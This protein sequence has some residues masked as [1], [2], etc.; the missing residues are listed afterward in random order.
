MT[1]RYNTL[2][3]ASSDGSGTVTTSG[4]GGGSGQTT[5]NQANNYYAYFEFPIK[6]DDLS[7]SLSSLSDKKKFGQYIDDMSLRD[8]ILEDYINTNVVNAVIGDSYIKTSQASGVV[9]F[10]WQGPQ[11]N[12]A[13]PT[14]NQVMQYNSTTSKW[15]NSTVVGTQGATGSQ[16]ATGPQGATGASGTSG[17]TTGPSVVTM[18]SSG[19]ASIAHGISGTP[20]QVIVTNGDYNSYPHGI[21]LYT[22]PGSTY[23]IVQS[24]GGNF[25]GGC[26]VNWLAFP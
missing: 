21:E 19:Q 13:S 2:A 25:S 22:T 17:W 3:V 10:G 14:N 4:L 23:F 24:V 26:R 11:F 9:S 5:V 12:I 18:N 6:W 7:D 16:G 15:F 8:N 1:E 20:S